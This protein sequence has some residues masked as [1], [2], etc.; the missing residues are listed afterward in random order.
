VAL[1]VGAVVVCVAWGVGDVWAL[2]V[3]IATTMATQATAR[4]AATRIPVVGPLGPSVRLIVLAPQDQRLAAC[5]FITEQPSSL[6]LD[7]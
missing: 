6:G 7:A 1:G 5:D 4:T 3:D 2:A